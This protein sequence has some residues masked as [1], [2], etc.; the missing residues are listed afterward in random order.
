VDGL[1]LAAN[2]G[3]L[4]FKFDQSS[5][6]PGFANQAGVP[7]YQPFSRP[8][9][10]GNVSAQYET[11]EVAAGGH[12]VFR[13]DANFTS[14]NLLTSDVSP[15]NANDPSRPLFDPTSAVIP[16]SAV[17][18]DPVL[19]KAATVPSQWIVNGRVAFADFDIAGTKAEIALWGRNIFDADNLAQFVGLGPVGSAIYERQRSYG[20]DVSFRI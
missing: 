11:P 16:F 1:T 10:T 9:W 12:F 14:K 4:H 5:V 13:I 6:F 7:G 17:V 8:K 3:Y 18:E 20:V 2:V 15:L 19:R